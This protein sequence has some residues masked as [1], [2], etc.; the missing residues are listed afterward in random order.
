MI[1]E[2]VLWR[3]WAADIVLYLGSG[4]PQ[5][6][7]QL[8]QGI[9]GISDRVLAERLRELEASALIARE[10]APGPPVRVWYRLTAA[11]ER[12]VPPLRDL[13]AVEATA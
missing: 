5:R 12:F 1:R 10:V 3:A 9:D 13:L 11:G 6:F 4:D 2:H 7:N 8:M